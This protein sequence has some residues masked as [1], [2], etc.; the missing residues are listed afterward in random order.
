MLNYIANYIIQ[1]KAYNKDF[2]DKHVQFETATTDIGYG[3]R[4]ENPLEQ[5]AANAGVGKKRPSSFEEFAK[6]VEPY[7]L[8]YVSALS[9]VPQENL[10]RAGA[11]PMPTRTRRSARSGPWAST[12]TPAASG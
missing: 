10:L 8:E 4:P 11:R 5:K 12:S 2:I 1:T 9:G 3:L 6:Q 7:T